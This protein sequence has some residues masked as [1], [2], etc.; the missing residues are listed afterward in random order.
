MEHQQRH[1]EKQDERLAS[2]ERFNVQT[3]RMWIS[4][5]RKIDL[6]YED[7]DLDS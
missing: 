5:A 2:M 4:I 6:D 7:P 3:R 1:L